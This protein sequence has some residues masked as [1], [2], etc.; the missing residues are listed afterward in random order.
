MSAPIIIWTLRRTG[1]TNLANAMFQLAGYKAIEHE[2]F[3]TDRSFGHIL[4]EYNE[5]KDLERLYENI[6]DVVKNG[7]SIKHCIELMPEEFNIALMELCVRY[8]YRHVFL[9][10]E[11][12]ADR[13]LSLNYAQKTGIW[14]RDQ[15]DQC[16]I[17][18]SVFQDPID[19]NG[20]LGHEVTCQKE[21]RSI[22]ETLVDLNQTPL[23]VSFESLYKSDFDYSKRLVT[24]LF[25]ELELDSAA[26]TED[27]FKKILKKGAQGTKSDY[28]K[29]PGSENF[30][31]AAEEMERFSLHRY[32][33]IY[34]KVD[35]YG[36]GVG[37]LVVYLFKPSIYRE[38]YHLV[39][40][41]IAEDQSSFCV[42][43]FGHKV[44]MLT[45]MKSNNFAANH[46]GLP[47][48]ETAR[49]ISMATHISG[50]VRLLL[51]DEVVARV[52]SPR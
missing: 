27:L 40:A 43:W 12:A 47:L 11:E 34:P 2:P 38:K 6:N 4:L 36:E 23:A 8:G 10:R 26:L 46:P 41:F 3:N 30:I 37:N 33:S 44:T 32:S 7:Y 39:G 17:D 13:L 19:T 50:G 15:R 9:Y 14:G 31:K 18:E 35:L 49:F 20:L 22:Y 29:F 25:L 42:D 1:G 45:R 52:H 21:L 51:N 16:E 5:N 48:A 24:D 28:L